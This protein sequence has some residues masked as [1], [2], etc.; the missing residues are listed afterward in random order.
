[1][2]TLVRISRIVC[3]ALAIVFITVPF[4]YTQE[5]T[6]PKTLCDN[7]C[8]A[9]KTV[10][11]FSYDA[12]FV[13]Y[14]N[15]TGVRFKWAPVTSE[16]FDLLG[17]LVYNLQGQ[18]LGIITGFVVD[19]RGRIAFATLWQPSPEIIPTGRGRH[20]AVPFSALSIRRT[21]LAEVTVV[22]NMEKGTMSSAPSFDGTN[23]L[24]NIEWAAR[25]YQYFGQAPYWTEEEA[26][27]VHLS[28]SSS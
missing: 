23:D 28:K 11:Q 2:K 21:R 18:M 26:G 22:L 13:A 24:N 12:G 14:S 19:T 25:V 6:T 17:S 4:G 15:L 16:T 7:K 27:K 9:V 10:V 3:L 5:V 8:G 1:M 20:V